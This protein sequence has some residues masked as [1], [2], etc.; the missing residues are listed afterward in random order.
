MLND[1]A[2]V[3][4]NTAGIEGAGGAGGIYNPSGTVTLN[5]FATVSHNTAGTDGGGIFNTNGGTVTGAVAGRNVFANKPDD[6]A[7]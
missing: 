2:T 7:T 6:I 4:G 3:S 5:D 1:N